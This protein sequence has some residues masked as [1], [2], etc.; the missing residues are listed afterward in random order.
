M[1]L[2][3]P[4]AVAA[5]KTTLQFFRKTLQSHSLF[6]RT[7]Y[8]QGLVHDCNQTVSGDNLKVYSLVVALCCLLVGAVTG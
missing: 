4:L 7:Q 5:E 3:P 6:R 1:K 2:M 8:F